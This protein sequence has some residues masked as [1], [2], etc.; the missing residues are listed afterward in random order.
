MMPIELSMDPLEPLAALR[1]TDFRLKSTSFIV[2]K[3]I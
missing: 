3:K 2:A 1:N